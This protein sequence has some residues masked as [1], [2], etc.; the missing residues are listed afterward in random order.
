MISETSRIFDLI[1]HLEENYN[2]KEDLFARKLK[3]RWVKYSSSTYTYYADRLSSGFLSLGLKKGDMIATITYNSP[4]FNFLDMGM[5]Q[6]GVT[7]VP[8]YPTLSEKDILFILKDCK[9]KILIISNSDIYQHIKQ[10]LTEIESLMDI[11][12]IETV[13]GI[14]SWREIVESG[15]KNFNRNL[16]QEDKKKIKNDDIATIIYTSGTTGKPKGVMLS[17]QNI[18]SN[19]L[20]VSQIPNFAPA[21]KAL[22]FLPLCHIYERMLNYMFQYMGVSIYYAESIEQISENIHEIKP[23]IFAAVPRLLEKIYEKIVMKG[24]TLSGL[25]KILFF[26]ALHFAENWEFVTRK[27]LIYRLKYTIYDRLIFKRWRE[28]LGNNVKMI[29]SGGANL[30]PKVCRTFWAA[31]IKVMI[32]YG[33]TETSPVIAV[34]DLSPKGFKFGTVGKV[35]KNTE[36]KITD[37]GEIICKGSGVMKGYWNRPDRNK[38]VFDSEGWFHTG[39]IGVLDKDGFLSITD[40]KKEVFKTSGGKYIAPQVIESKLVSSPFIEQ[41]LV[42]GENQKYPAALIVPNFE[43]LRS[44]CKLKEILYKTNGTAIHNDLIRA[45][46]DREIEQLNE[47]LGQSEKIKRW[48][49]LEHEWTVESGELSPTLKLRRKFIIAKNLDIIRELYKTQG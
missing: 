28:A 34:T 6:V 32:G 30:Q 13:S 31:K 24:R 37:D 48:V 8:I 19:F 2:F 33:L 22:S 42:V 25:K 20:T 38:E 15:K 11:Y 39:D 17:H 4:E 36:L 43:Y 10:I 12:S 14:K 5:M 16:L 29:V 21:D 44:W 27:T 49:Y 1:P 41:A 35:L 23:A 40:R 7:H 3:G 45:R 9:A 18:I 47:I 46:L 26:N